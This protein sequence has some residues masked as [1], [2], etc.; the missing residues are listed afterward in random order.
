[1]SSNPS[2]NYNQTDKDLIASLSKKRLPNVKQLKYLG[3]FLNSKESMILAFGALLTLVGVG[4]FAYNFYNKNVAVQPTVGGRYIEGAVGSP[5]FINPLYASLNSVD[6]DLAKLIYSSLFTR[7]KNGYLAKDLVD[8][9]TVSPDQKTY[10]FK[11]KSGVKWQNGEDLT[12]DDVIFTIETIQDP[13]FH[14]PLRSQLIGVEAAKIDDLTFTL[15]LPESFAPFAE[16]LTFGIMPKTAWEEI[17]ASSVSLADLNLKPIGSGPY[18][19]SSLIKDKSGSIRSYTLEANK[20]Y[21]RQ[22]PFI[23][24]IVFKFFGAQEE[25]VGAINTGQIDGA[26]YLNSEDIKSINAKNSYSFNHLHIPQNT[27]LFFNLRN[28]EDAIADKKVREALALAINK[29]ELINEV[30]G[31]NAEAINSPINPASFGFSENT[32][33]Y[34]YNIAEAKRLIGEA[35]WKMVASSTPDGTNT[36]YLAKDGKTLELKI[37]VPDSMENIKVAEGV[38]AAWQEL[39]AKVSLDIIGKNDVQSLIIRPKAFSIMLYGWLVGVD[40]DPYQMWH[41]SQIGEKGMNLSGY[42][43]SQVD[44]LLEDGRLNSNTEVRKASY[45]EFQ[46]LL[47]ADLPA[48]F[49]Y[50]PH[51]L[52]ALNKEI[53]GF[54]INII[55]SPEDRLSGITGWFIKQSHSLN[56]K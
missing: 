34:A 11:L 14:S 44:K 21:Y 5:Q 31:E 22:K 10:T 38:S 45:T 17:S 18:E 50:T 4:L 33:N 40:P 13:A 37:T 1:M 12:A 53:K 46:K 41:S 15:T 16:S 26:S 3:K 28:K 29:P 30:F 9:Y 27:A 19:F 39:G 54:D 56:L 49:L 6:A 35:G 2:Y 36:G 25:I 8:S 55:T 51:Y 42:K 47:T 48:I 7:D 32:T 24:K 23:E 52:Y 20:L 43:N